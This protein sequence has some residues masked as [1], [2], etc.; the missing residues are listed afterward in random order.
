[1]RKYNRACIG[2]DEGRKTANN[3]PLHIQVKHKLVTQKGKTLSQFKLTE[4]LRNFE[5]STTLRPLLKA[6]KDF[7]RRNP[8]GK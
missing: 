8:I 1:M 6:G 4:P 7:D 2:G 3:T 5:K